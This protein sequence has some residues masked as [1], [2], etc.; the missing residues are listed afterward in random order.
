MHFLGLTKRLPLPVGN[1]SLD[2]HLL[3]SWSTHCQN[4]TV[5]LRTELSIHL[6]RAMQTSGKTIETSVKKAIVIGGGIGGLT[7]ARACVDAGIEVELYEKR[8]LDGMLSGPGGIFIQ[9]NAMGIYKLLWGGKIY[10]L[11]YERGGKIL[12]GGFSSKKSSSSVY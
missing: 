7:F 12:S 2:R 5:N 10:Q 3:N 11:L 6:G 9:R 4:S 1:K 8:Q